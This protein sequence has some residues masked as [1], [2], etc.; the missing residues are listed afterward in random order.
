MSLDPKYFRVRSVSDI[1]FISAENTEDDFLF[2]RKCRRES[3]Q[4]YFSHTSTSK[5]WNEEEEDKYERRLFDLDIAKIVLYK[6]ERAGFM[7]LKYLPNALYLDAIHL[8][9]PFQGKKVGAF[10]MQHVL[11]E[12]K[13][14]WKPVFLS[15]YTLNEPAINFYKKFGFEI[16]TENDLNSLKSEYSFLENEVD[17]A[18]RLLPEN[19]L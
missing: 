13:E 12:C 5:E 6:G 3:G 16:L 9:K 19:L 4:Q 15:V 1:E 14:T 11:S 10:C 18:M 8:L 7:I 2:L 17:T